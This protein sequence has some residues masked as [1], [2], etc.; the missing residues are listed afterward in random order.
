MH[1]G[2]NSQDYFQFWE[3]AMHMK[4]VQF[5]CMHDRSND[6]ISVEINFAMVLTLFM[7]LLQICLLTLNQLSDGSL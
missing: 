3:R 1:Q 6:V 5:T 7:N 4:P 2:R